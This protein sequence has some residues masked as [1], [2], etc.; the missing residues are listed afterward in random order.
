MGNVGNGD[1]LSQRERP[2]K[3]V[4]STS[5]D[6]ERLL[7]VMQQM[8]LFN[9]AHSDYFKKLRKFEMAWQPLALYLMDTDGKVAGGLIAH[10]NQ[11]WGWMNIAHVWVDDAM[12]GRGCGS[13]LIAR[14]EQ[15]AKKRECNR[16]ELHT[17][18][19]QA[20][21]FY[22]KHGYRE[23]GRLDDNPPGFT[24]YWMTKNIE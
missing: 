12:R 7:Y 9:D 2:Y 5:T 8:K 16:V 14:A 24:R 11:A 3:I 13:E 23:I 10:T 19:F 4:Y 17:W 21:E 22:K 18:S 15:E 20:P 1:S 6:D